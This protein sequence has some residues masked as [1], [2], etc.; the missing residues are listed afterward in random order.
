VKRRFEYIMK[1]ERI[2]FIDDYAHHPEELKSIDN[3][4]KS[5]IQAKKMYSDLSTAS[6]HKNKRPG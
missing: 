4:S 6:V 1:N 2:V 5:F 3:R